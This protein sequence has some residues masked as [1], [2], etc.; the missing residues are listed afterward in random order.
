MNPAGRLRAPLVDYLAERRSAGDDGRTILLGLDRQQAVFALAVGLAGE[1]DYPGFLTFSRYLLH[2][3]YSC[4]G[5]VLM[6]PAAIA[7]RAVYVVEL[8]LG[9]GLTIDVVEEDGSARR[10]P[11]ASNPIGDLGQRAR[12]LPAI[13]RREL[14]RLYERLR[15]PP[16]ALAL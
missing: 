2:H 6:L 13:Q 14:D 9:E 1:P 3:R 10:A 4:D 5:H 7:R 11:V 16:P 8:K 15:V 12:G